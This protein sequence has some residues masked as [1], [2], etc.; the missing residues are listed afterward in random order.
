MQIQAIQY[1]SFGG[2][3]KKMSTKSGYSILVG[4]EKYVVGTH[5]ESALKA[6][7]AADAVSTPFRNITSQ[8][9][10]NKLN[11]LA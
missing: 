5:H 7:T 2:N 11:V 3:A 8:T 10:G 6:N 4:G 1:E 9:T